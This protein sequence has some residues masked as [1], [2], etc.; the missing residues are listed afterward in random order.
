MKAHPDWENFIRP[1]LEKPYYIELKNFLK[2]EMQTKT[3]YPKTENWFNALS[4]S[5]DEVKVIIIGQDP[6]HGDNQAHGFSFSVQKGVAIPPS[7]VNIYK[8]IAREFNVEMSKKNGDLTPWVN[9]GVMLLNSILTVER[10][11]AAS[12][13]GQGWETFTDKIIQTISDNFDNKVFMLWGNYA[14]GK[15]NLI[16]KNRHLI[17]TSAHPSPLARG[18]FDGNGHFLKANEYLKEHNMNP[19]DWQIKD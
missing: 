15:Q 5:P 3:I 4:L 9:Q 16:D 19:I 7:L 18:A 11:R 2:K 13:R 6:Y 14:I 10:N 17:L 12:H 8:E 1:E